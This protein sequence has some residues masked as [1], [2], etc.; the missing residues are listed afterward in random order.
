MKNQLFTNFLAKQMVGTALAALL[1]CTAFAGGVNDGGGNAHKA[2]LLGPNAIK[3]ILSDSKGPLVYVFR[4][5]EFST[6]LDKNA[7]E[8]DLSLRIH[9]KLFDGP[10]S[11]FQALKEAN[12]QPIEHGGCPD[13]SGKEN[14]ASA[15]KDAPNICFS[16][17]FLEKK[18]HEDSGNIEL[19]ALVAHEVSHLAGTDE[20][21]AE[22]IQAIVR[23]HISNHT[24]SR[25]EENFKNYQKK[26]ADTLNT[27]T[28]ILSYARASRSAFVCM[29]LQGLMTA[30]NELMQINFDASSNLGVSFLGTEGMSFVNAA[31][32]KSMNAA[33]SC[34][35]DEF[36]FYDFS[37]SFFKEKSSRPLKEFQTALAASNNQSDNFMLHVPD[38]NIR[39][40]EKTSN[41]S[42]IA[43]L[44]DIQALLTQLQANLQ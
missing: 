44:E 10:K 28:V 14:D 17:E 6:S 33:I 20:T 43:E 25:F 13:L 12:L 30:N 24:L 5:I 29:G 37:K 4:S 31:T 36:N 22:L 27:T 2:P 41:K 35:P 8:Q 15:L 19:L 7:S 21:E 16:L 39:K 1:S 32:L 9:R 26:V 18:L 11:I 40:I 34:Y 23:E 38:M 3:K 42:L